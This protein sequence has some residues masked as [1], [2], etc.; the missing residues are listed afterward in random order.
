MFSNAFSLALNQKKNQG[1]GKKKVRFTSF[2]FFL[3]FPVVH[4]AG[5]LANNSKRK[6]VNW[7]PFL[8]PSPQQGV[9]FK[10]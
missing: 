6:G 8:F 7:P 9:N 5:L 10:A 3:F 4:Q 2:F 1:R